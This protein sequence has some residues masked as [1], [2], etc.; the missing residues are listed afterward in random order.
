MT[1]EP[2][3]SRL[4]LNLLVAL[5]ALLSE[6]SVTRAAERLHLSQPALSASLSRLRTHFDDRLLLRR[7]NASELT[8]LARRLADRTATALD[9][10]RLV[11]DSRTTWDPTTS[12]RE[13]SVY[14][15]DHAFATIG[16]R[17]SLIA[18]R[19]APGARLRFTLHNEAIVE[20]MAERLRTTDAMILPH[21]FARG[22]PHLDLW[23]EDWVLVVAEENRAAARGVRL[24]DLAAARWVYTYQSRAA[25]T[26]AGRQLE[27]LGIEPDVVAVVES[28]L[29]MPA[30]IVG[31]ERFGL[32]HRSLST[33]ITRVEGVRVVEPPFEVTPILNAL[34][35]DPAND[36]DPEHAWLRDVFARAGREV[37]DSLTEPAGP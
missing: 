35:W 10:A 21:G 19:E 32:V 5:D 18:E 14:G 13:F 16:R 26:P 11:F 3:L 8:P 27:Q 17:A 4:D 30:F 22:L 24:E 37:A 25:F 15:S 23:R 29:A 6:R 1:D 12:T 9:A 7:G 34:W 20:A 33:F 2:R 28:F 31:T 36:D